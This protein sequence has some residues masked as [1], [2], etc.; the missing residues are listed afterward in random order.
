VS[1]VPKASSLTPADPKIEVVLLLLIESFRFSLAPDKEIYWQT[2][3]IAKPSV[4][5]FSDNRLPLVVERV[6]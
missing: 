3:A 6:V 1:H 2:Q 4:V 5:G